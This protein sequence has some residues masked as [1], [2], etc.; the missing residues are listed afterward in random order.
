MELMKFLAQMEHA[1]SIATMAAKSATDNY[2]AAH[3]IMKRKTD[4]IS[5]EDHD[6]DVGVVYVTRRTWPDGTAE[7]P[8]LAEWTNSGWKVLSGILLQTSASYAGI[9]VLQVT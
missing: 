8:C 3:S 1:A 7:K 9:Q 4:W 2:A 5:V 6:L